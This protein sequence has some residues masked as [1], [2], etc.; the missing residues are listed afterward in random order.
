VTRARLYLWFAIRL[1]RLADRLLAA[2][3]RSAP[4]LPAIR[5]DLTQLQ[6]GAIIMLP[7]PD[8]MAYLAACRAR[9]AFVYMGKPPEASA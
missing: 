6:P 1:S 4:P 5:L 7:L 2:S 8:P 9:E 3:R